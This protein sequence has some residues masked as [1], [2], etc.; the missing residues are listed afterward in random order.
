MTRHELATV[1]AA[2]LITASAPFAHA[3]TPVGTAFTYQGR[4]DDNSQPA[5]G[6]FDL[7]FTLFDAIT[8]GNAVGGAVV[9]ADVQVT[10]G[11]FTVNLDFGAAAFVGNARWLEIEVRPGGSG[12]AFTV[13]APRQ[14]LTPGPNALFSSSAADAA[15]LGGKPPTSYQARITGTCAAG[16]SIRIVGQD[17]SVVCEVDDDT[18]GWNLTGN[19]STNPATN[20]IGT[21]DNQAFELRANNQRVLRIEPQAAAGTYQGPSVLAGYQGNLVGP[22]VQGAV[23]AGGGGLVGGSPEVNEVAAEFGTVGGGLDN[24]VGVSGFAATVGGG[25]GNNAS[26]SGATVGGGGNN[27]ASGL[28]AT[29]PGGLDSQAGG[30]H[31]FAAG[32]RAKVRDGLQAGNL[33]GDDGTFAWADNHS[34]DFISTGPNQ[35]LVRAAGGVGINTN[36]PMGDLQLGMPG[37]PSAFRFGNVATRN[38]LI[39]NRDMVFNAFSLGPAV[40]IFRWRRNTALFDETGFVELMTLNDVGDLDINGVLSKG[41]GS[42]KIDH[43]L[44]PD[45]KYLYHSFVESPDMKNVYDGVVT[46]GDDGFATVELPEWFEALNRDFRYQLTVIG[47]GEWARARVAQEVEVNRFVVETDRPQVRVS[48]QVTGIRQDTFAE[49]HRIP[50]E[51]DKPESERGRRLHAP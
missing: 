1:L 27:T 39:S 28:F 22:G 41:G 9:L 15:M 49:K 48:W 16:Q 44:D 23:V 25:S 32:R 29:V 7:R 31:S 8:N 45:N 30:D 19:A 42:F 21:T 36:A 40:P 34:S 24:R 20:F 3:Q 43:P 10:A 2:G 51:V 17:G 38:H 14:E 13:L 6:S 12:G 4:L 37:H 5:G 46:T 11:L 33:L 26:N 35:F 47:G 50:V 18:P